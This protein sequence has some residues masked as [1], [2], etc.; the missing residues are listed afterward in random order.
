MT[1]AGCNIQASAIYKIE[2]VDPARR[3]TVDEL[4][5]LARVFGRSI[6]DLLRPIGVL[7]QESAHQLLLELDKAAPGP[8][9]LAFGTAC[10]GRNDRDLGALNH[11]SVQS[12]EETDI[13]ITDVDIDETAKRP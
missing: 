3:I 13:V 7:D 4:I 5:A 9:K 10:N 1:D 11:L 2:K 12:A 6:D 8:H